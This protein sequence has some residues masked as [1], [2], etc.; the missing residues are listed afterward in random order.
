MYC[1]PKIHKPGNSV[2]P[3]VSS[4]NSPTYLLSKWLVKEFSYLPN[5]PQTF[6]VENSKC[7][8]SEDFRIFKKNFFFRK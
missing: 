3:I 6:S 4:I 2:R 8:N 7:T 5:Q 1:L